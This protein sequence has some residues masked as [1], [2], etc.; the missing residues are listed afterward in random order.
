MKKNHFQTKLDY[1]KNTLKYKSD[2][3]RK[4]EI[5]KFKLDNLCL[6]SDLQL[7][8]KVNS[9][10]PNKWKDI[11]GCF[12][13]YRR[14]KIVKIVKFEKIF[15]FNEC[16]NQIIFKE[17]G[18][19]DYKKIDFFPDYR[20][21]KELKNIWSDLQ[22]SKKK[23]NEYIKVLKSHYKK[24]RNKLLINKLDKVMKKGEFVNNYLN[25]IFKDFK[26][27]VNNND[28]LCKLK[29]LTFQ[30]GNFPKYINSIQQFYLLKYFYAFFTEY[31]IMYQK[32]FNNDFKPPFKILS[33]GAGA[34]IDYYSIKYLMRDRGLNIKNNLEYTGVDIVD[35]GYKP[36]DKNITFIK[37]DISN[38]KINIDNYN[39][40]I[41]PKSLGELDDD[42]LLI[43]KKLFEHSSLNSSQVAILGS[44][45]WSQS[46]IDISIFNELVIN[47][48]YNSNYTSVLELETD[49]KDVYH[50]KEILNI[51]YPNKIKNYIDKLDTKC[52]SDFC[53]E[54]ISCKD[55]LIRTPM[56]YSR[57]FC[58]QIKILKGKIPF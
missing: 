4:I 26:N 55:K 10:Q 6:M 33:L 52:N 40:F 48:Y 29:D 9:I 16:F 35:W 30:R 41:F 19:N 14:K 5:L 39:I 51:E 45:R 27:Y 37:S 56:F 25:I 1:F 36:Q 2:I 8:C 32:L 53:E 50:M 31:Y 49:K 12:I 44:H 54:T 23:R 42:A 58:N 20:D 13:T 47:I 17:K 18:T 46:N 24:E 22:L 11:I 34:F 43:I 28:R 21:Y 57:W 38:L 7:Y 3:E 15:G